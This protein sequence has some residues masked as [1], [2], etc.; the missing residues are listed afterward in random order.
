MRLLALLLAAAAVQAVPDTPSWPDLLNGHEGIARGF[1]RTSAELDAFQ[2]RCAHLAGPW[3]SYLAAHSALERVIVLDARHDWNGLG[4][5]LERYVFALRAGRVLGRA[6]FLQ[7]DA[8]SESAAD[9]PTHLRGPHR[10]PAHHRSGGGCPAAAAFDPG[11][12]VTGIAGLDWHWSHSAAARVA[13]RHGLA[14]FKELTL[15]CERFDYTRGCVRMVLIAGGAPVLTADDANSTAV[16]ADALWTHLR[17]AYAGEPLLRLILL[18]Q[19]DLFD[20]ASLQWACDAVGQPG[21]PFSDARGLP[22]RCDLRCEAFA[23]WRP[24]PRTWA[25]LAPLVNQV[26]AWAGAVGVMLRSGAADHVAAHGD[27]LQAAAA[28][29]AAPAATEAALAALFEP[30]KRGT[31]PLRDLA[32]D[33]RPCVVYRSDDEQPPGRSDVTACGGKYAATVPAQ[34]PTLPGPLG[35]YLDCAAREAAAIAFSATSDASAGHGIVL[36]TDAPA[37]KCALESSPLAAAGHVATTPSAPGHVAFAPGGPALEAVA[38]AAIVDH[39]LMG[40]LDGVLLS[41]TSSAYAGAASVRAPGDPRG[42]QVAGERPAVMRPGMERWFA[43]GRENLVGADAQ[44]VDKG[45]LRLLLA[46]TAGE[47]PVTASTV[48]HTAAAYLKSAP[49]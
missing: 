36:F 8:C 20:A 7:T 11:R 24:R 49:S 14:T 30:C 34:P 25:A 42:G 4:D 5:S 47:C 10:E 13:A 6:T 28:T 23:N 41:A 1:R 9:F 18:N 27:A 35:A 33:Q 32:P 15:R 21:K 46:A 16:V 2:S 38:V 26:D 48:A 37:F 43:V 22:P 44:K 3:A 12:H 45:R 40:L 29:P 31:P 17:D 39:Y 19:A